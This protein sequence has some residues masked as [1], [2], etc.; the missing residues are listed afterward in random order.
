MGKTK[1]SPHQPQS[2]DSKQP[3]R[4][5]HTKTKL[6]NCES[7]SKTQLRN[8]RKRRA[9]QRCDPSTPYISNPLAAPTVQRAK[10]YFADAFP[11]HCSARKGWRTVAKLAV[12]KV[13]NQITIGLYAPRSHSIVSVPN[14]TAHHDAINEAVAL[15]QSTARNLNTE[16]LRYVCLNVE[17]SSS[18][19]QLTL[20][21]K[22]DGL[23]RLANSLW[24]KHE[25]RFH[26]IWIHLNGLASHENSIWDMNGSWKRIHGTD[27]VVET[28]A[29][30]KLYFAPQVFRQ[31]NLDAFEKIVIAIRKYLEKNVAKKNGKLQCLE[32]YGGVGT[33]GLP[34]VDLVELV[35][36]DANP[37]N[38]TCFEKAAQGRASYF[39]KNAVDMVEQHQDLVDKA[40][41]IL[42]DPPRKG[43]DDPVAKALN[44]TSNAQTLVYVSC[45]FAALERDLKL[46]TRWKVDHAQGHVL[47][48]GSDAIETLVFL[49]P[50]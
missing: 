45:G 21:G 3:Q 4:K 27:L 46:L 9:K 44:G 6:K 33:L 23:E 18:L 41:V 13:R 19:I 11:I 43:L 12:G 16:T 42:V 24:K 36:S 34:L 22:T 17:R 14:C 37:Y 31:A 49:K 1:R 29:N 25:K 26:S 15:I 2:I 5:L 39:T 35:S 20:I 50:K 28:V 30:T 47:F 10:A 7:L 32:L 38:K 48:P 40:Q 8:A